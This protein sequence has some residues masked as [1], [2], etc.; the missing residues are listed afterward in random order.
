ML[1]LKTDYHLILNNIRM[2]GVVEIVVV[3]VVEIMSRL[4]LDQD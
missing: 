2:R 4:K 3:L 1:T